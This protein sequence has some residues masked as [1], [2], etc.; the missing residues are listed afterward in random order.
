M[1]GR[2]A[3]SVFKTTNTWLTKTDVKMSGSCM[4]PPITNDVKFAGI[5]KSNSFSYNYQNEK[6]CLCVC[7]IFLPLYSK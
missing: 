2:G 6:V 5:K 4:K 1:G 3:M 7:A